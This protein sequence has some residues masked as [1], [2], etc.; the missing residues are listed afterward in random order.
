[1]TIYIL[2]ADHS[3]V[4]TLCDAVSDQWGPLAARTLAAETV[5]TQPIAPLIAPCQG[6]VVVTGLDWPCPVAE[7]AQRADQDSQ[8]RQALAAQ[9]IAYRVLYGPLQRRLENAVAAWQAMQ[10]NATATAGSDTAATM[11]AQPAPTST[12]ENR[13]RMRALG[14][15]KCSDPVCEHRLFTSLKLGPDL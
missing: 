5:L 11:A 14:C 12:R 9:G 1:M 4:Q 7:L 10:P 8:L 3:G 6:G 15:E 13:A 2:G